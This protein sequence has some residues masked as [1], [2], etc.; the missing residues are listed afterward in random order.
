VL[1]LVLSQPS[2]AGYDVEPYVVLCGLASGSVLGSGP[3][4]H[5]ERYSFYA[6]ILLTFG[7]FLFASND[8]PPK[9]RLRSADAPKCY[10]LHEEVRP[11]VC[12]R[13]FLVWLILPVKDVVDSGSARLCVKARL[14]SLRCAAS[15]VTSSRSCFRRIFR[16]R[17]TFSPRVALEARLLLFTDYCPGSLVNISK[18]SA[19]SFF[20]SG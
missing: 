4:R 20:A 12:T 10:T 18:S 14:R 11:F 9:W 1:S 17:L 15:E 7:S 13:R 16:L 6:R 8:D 3:L 19:F 2:C 5:S